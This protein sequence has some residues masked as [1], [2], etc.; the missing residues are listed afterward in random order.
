MPFLKDENRQ[1]R[2]TAAEAL[3]RIAAPNSAEAL[4]AALSDPEHV[5]RDYAYKTLR[6]MTRVDCGIYPD[7]WELWLGRNKIFEPPL[8]KEEEKGFLERIFLFLAEV[9][10]QI[11]IRQED[12]SD[13]FS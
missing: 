4:V 9:F 8:I 5:V 3:C 10:Q 6:K 11:M 1:T 2:I 13:Y 12:L 7:A